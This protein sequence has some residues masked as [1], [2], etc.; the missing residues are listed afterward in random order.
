MLLHLR[1]LEGLYSITWEYHRQTRGRL[2]RNLTWVERGR[3]SPLRKKAKV[4]GGKKSVMWQLSEGHA[5][6]P[7]SRK[8]FLQKHSC[9]VVWLVSRASLETSTNPVVI[10]T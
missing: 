10:R 6:I 1:L 3:E 5:P 4:W 2:G 9:P 8:A 7:Y